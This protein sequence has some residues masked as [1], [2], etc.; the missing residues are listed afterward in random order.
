MLVL[1]K[2]KKKDALQY[3][4]IIKTK[5]VKSEATSE[6]FSGWKIYL[7]IPKTTKDKY[8]STG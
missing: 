4:F 1:I 7:I 2:K 3:L 5:L 6:S 8:L